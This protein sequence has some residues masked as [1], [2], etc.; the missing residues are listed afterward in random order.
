MTT[1]R[2][3]TAIAIAASMLCLTACGTLFT[4]MENPHIQFN[5]TAENVKANG[6]VQVF[7]IGA[8]TVVQIKDISE[9]RPTFIGDFGEEIKYELF[10]QNAVLNGIH[11][12]FSIVSSKGTSK[13]TR[14]DALGHNLR[15]KESPAAQ[16]IAVERNTT[17]SATTSIEKLKSENPEVLRSEIARMRKELAELKSMISNI[18]SPDT[19]PKAQTPAQESTPQDSIKERSIV[20][21]Q[22]S[23]NS[24]AFEPDAAVSSTLIDLATGASHVAVKGFTDSFTPT[25]AAAN[26]AK[27]RAVAAKDYLV[28]KGISAQKISVTYRASGGFVSDNTTATGKARNRRVEIEIS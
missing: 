28:S 14:N 5:Y 10:G 25:P 22:F 11:R 15:S 13:V 1:V 6:I 20:T 18:S 27:L 7:D 3:R 23:D 2:T 19:G 24:R 16:A 21:V 9:Y 4:K 8:N 26:L 12:S 17:T